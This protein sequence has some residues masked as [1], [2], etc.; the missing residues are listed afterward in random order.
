MLIMLLFLQEFKGKYFETEQKNK[1]KS[2]KRI[3]IKTNDYPYSKNNKLSEL[4]QK[5]RTSI[6]CYFQ[7]RYHLLNFWNGCISLYDVKLVLKNALKKK[8]KKKHTLV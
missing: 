4:E 6:Q 1:I 3:K 7:Y 2:Y 5:R 8:L